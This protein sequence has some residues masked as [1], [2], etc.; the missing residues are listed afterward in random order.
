M[1]ALSFLQVMMPALLRSLLGLYGSPGGDLVDGFL[2]LNVAFPIVRVRGTQNSG[3]LGTTKSRLRHSVLAHENGALICA[4]VF[5]IVHAACSLPCAIWA[6]SYIYLFIYIY[7]YM[8]RAQ[9]EAHL[10]M[11]FLFFEDRCLIGRSDL[12]CR[13]FAEVR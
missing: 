4:L 7:I 1:P 12:R 9:P 10:L 3:S 5:V 11:I 8:V 13:S 2:Q 6:R